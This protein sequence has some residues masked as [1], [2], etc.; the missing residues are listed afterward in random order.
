MIK[1]T[2]VL[3]LFIGRDVATPQGPLGLLSHPPSPPYC[4]AS[5]V[6]HPSPA[7]DEDEDEAVVVARPR[8]SAVERPYKLVHAQAGSIRLIAVSP[9]VL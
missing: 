8:R 6:R 9:A 4:Q 7:G 3:L 1:K 5:I 2:I